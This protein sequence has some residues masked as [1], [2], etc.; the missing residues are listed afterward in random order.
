MKNNT[1]AKVIMG[2]LAFLVVAGGSAYGAA[3]FYFAPMAFEAGMQQGAAAMI[4]EIVGR[5]IDTEKCEPINLYSGEAKVDLL[6]VKCI[7]QQ[8]GVENT[9]E[10]LSA[11]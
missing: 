2:V 10:E 5:T 3:Y 9:V 8:E 7:N 1:I 11:E 6:N 4:T